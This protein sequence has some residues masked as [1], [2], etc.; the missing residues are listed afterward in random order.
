[1]HFIF[2]I[3]HP[4]A[5]GALRVGWYRK[6]RERSSVRAWKESNLIY[7][8]AR[9]THN[10]PSPFK[11]PLVSRDD[12]PWVH[13]GSFG[14]KYSRLPPLLLPLPHTVARIPLQSIIDSPSLRSASSA[15]S[16]NTFAQDD[17]SAKAVGAYHARKVTTAIFP[18]IITVINA[19]VHF[20]HRFALST[21]YVPISNSTH[22]CVS[23]S[24]LCH[25]YHRSLQS[26]LLLLLYLRSSGE[27]RE[28][29]M[30]VYK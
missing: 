8:N 9:P 5:P 16:S 23:S 21:T 18:H 1:M 13:T 17:G 7:I 2:T 6:G 11:L 12:F 10:S 29:Y 24:G 19:I 20:S 28:T 22:G 14:S 27:G 4:F 30:S 3:S 25:F 26:L 15:R